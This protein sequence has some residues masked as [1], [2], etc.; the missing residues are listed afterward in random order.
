[1]D[2]LANLTE[3]WIPLSNFEDSWD[4]MVSKR[5]VKEGKADGIAKDGVL[6]ATVMREEFYALSQLMREKSKRTRAL[7][8]KMQAIVDREAELAR[9]ESQQ[10]EEYH[11]ACKGK[12][13]EGG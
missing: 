1:M 8:E 9:E 13:S 7:T 2:L 11:Q 4:E 10:R 3:F 6:F 12:E 5:A